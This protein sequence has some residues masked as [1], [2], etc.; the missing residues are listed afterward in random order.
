MIGYIVAGLVVGPA[1]P[2]P[3]AD[4]EEVLALADIGVALLMFSI[5]LQFSLHEI[6][7]IGARI[8]LGTPVQVAITMA[9]GTGTGLA[10][11]WGCPRR[12]SSARRS[13]SAR[14]WCW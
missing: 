5:G 1:T 4:R 9:L 7:S 10:L 8:L 3:T 13:R 2:G 11:G 6:R 12:C 14:P